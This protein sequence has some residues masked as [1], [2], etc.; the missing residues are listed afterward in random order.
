MTIAERVPLAPLTTFRIGGPAR[1][2]AECSDEDDIKA[3]L[4]FARER[5]LPYAVLGGGSNLLASD[6]GYDGVVIRPMLGAGAYAPAYEDQPD[7]SVLLTAGAG[8]SWDA[9]VASACERGLWGLENLSGIP[10]TLG[11]AVFQNIGAYGAALSQTLEWAEALDAQTGETR[12]F[13]LEECAFGY[14]I[15]RFKQDAGRYIILRAGLR[16][17]RALAPNLS[18]R[19]PNKAYKDIARIFSENP[20]P[21]LADIRRAIRSIRADKFPDLSREGTAGS[22]F[23]NPV[24]PESAARALLERYPDMPLF[25]M[26]ETAGM[27]V[28]AGWILDHVLHM[29]GYEMGRARLFE[30]QAMVVVARF[31][32][33]AAD[34]DALA[35]EVEKR[36]HGATGI[37][38]EREVRS[39]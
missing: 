5:G 18:Y 12:R 33:A 35:R 20:N 27:K 28:P 10:G 26:P 15:S 2:V 32:A 39:L 21:A 17:A 22:F 34:V 6:A 14:R 16:L 13:P 3:A 38:I 19:D 31:G 7:G 1:F 36:V 8:V 29:R 23:E 11:G 37:A 30:N 24:L 9:L 25:P 4:A